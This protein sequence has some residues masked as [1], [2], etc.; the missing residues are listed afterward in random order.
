MIYLNKPKN[1][2]P[3]FNVVSCFM[4]YNKKILLLHRQNYK[5]GGNSWGVPAG[6]VDT[7]EKILEAIIREIQEETGLTLIS[8]QLFYFK[9]IYVKYPNY[10]FIYHIFQTELNK[11]QK[12]V[13]NYEE[14]K[15]FKW[16]LPQKA[17]EM[18]LIP[19]LDACI[20]LFYKIKN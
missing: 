5:P 17:L 8:S 10:D 16:I 4:E 20:K 11:K 15:N 13:I 2:N 7:D 1:F 3:K 14:H 12:I 9:K 19:D 18:N 6:K